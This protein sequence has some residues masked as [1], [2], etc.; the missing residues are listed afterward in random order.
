METV[1]LWILQ[2]FFHRTSEAVGREAF[3]LAFCSDL[4]LSP[5]RKDRKDAALRAAVLGSFLG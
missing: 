1:Y 5:S 4:F 3:S 2:V